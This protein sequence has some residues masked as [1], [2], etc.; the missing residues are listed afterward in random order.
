MQK[1]W[2]I[3]LNTCNLKHNYIQKREGEQEQTLQNKKGEENKYKSEKERY[4]TLTD[5][6]GY[7]TRQEKRNER[8]T[9]SNQLNRIVI[10]TLNITIVI[11]EICLQFLFKYR[12][13]NR[14]LN[15]RVK[16]VPEPRSSTVTNQCIKSKC[17][18]YFGQVV[19]KCISSI[20][21][22]KLTICFK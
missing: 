13:A 11:N 22:M 8:L 4:G 21:V 15:V 12:K 3:N 7:D 5:M 18:P 9:N 17:C 20:I 19:R 2:S 1:K 6:D 10:N 16:R 14:L